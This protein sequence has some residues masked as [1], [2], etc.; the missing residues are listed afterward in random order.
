M[1]LSIIIVNYNGKHFLKDC[2]ESIALHCSSMDFEIIVVDNN[3]T[4]GSQKYIKEQFPQVVLLDMN[5][6]LGFGKANNTGVNQSKGENILLLNND[7]ILLDNLG[8]VIKEI[9]KEEIGIIGVKMLNGYKTYTP[10]VGKFPKP[11]DLIQLSN[12]NE[13]RKEF[14]NGSFMSKSYEV[15]W[16][17]GSF[18]LMKRKDWDKINGFDEDYFMYVEDVDLCKRMH[19]LG[20]KIVFITNISYIHFVGFNKSRE[21][22]LI[23]GYK[24]YSSK[25]FN[26]I[27]SIL[28]AI[29]LKI[30]Y[31]YKKRFK[32]IC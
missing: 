21:I 4:D 32:N 17:S 23:N 7:T 10:S 11:L 12:L 2:F 1:K 15:D 22:K 13:S 14:I 30:N 18:M 27:Y 5:N 29:C 9:E 16:V 20:K 3:S 24:L 25:H 28:A 6:N 8:E 19:N 26:Y 31:V